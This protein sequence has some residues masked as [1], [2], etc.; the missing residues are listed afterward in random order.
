M[1]KSGG[2][3]VVLSG[4]QDSTICLAWAV[5]YFGNEG[6]H[7]ISFD[8]GQRHKRELMSAH[9]VAG[10]AGVLSYEVIHLGPGL[11]RGTSPLLTGAGQAP[12][13]EPLEQYQDFA[14]MDAIIGNRV[15]KTFVPMRNA[16]FLTVAAN[17]A[18][19]LGVHK[20]I[21][22]VCQADNANYPDCRESFV[23][24]QAQT[25][26][27]AL[28]DDRFMVLAPLMHLSKSESIGLMTG[29]GLDRLSWLAFTHTAYDGM[30]PP[31]G[32]DHASVLRAHGFEQAN[33][34]DPLV[35]RAALIDRAMELPSTPNY[36]PER[37][38]AMTELGL[39]KH[40]DS[41]YARVRE[42]IRIPSP[43][44]YLDAVRQGVV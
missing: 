13:S 26:R 15:E 36:S 20:L 44:E 22:G 32:K 42:G 16:L 34:P 28:G 10:L 17:R 39:M 38:R 5:K 3:L 31:V 6:V 8:Y 29:I 33:I 43:D 23:D 12:G 4:G 9:V 2:V 37:I 35:L 1:N 7:A 18:V 14:S 27:E 21:T 19:C 30:Y 11:M 24:M 25:I 41:D 40:I